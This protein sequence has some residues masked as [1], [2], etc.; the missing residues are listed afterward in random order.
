M[1]PDCFNTLE[2]D[3]ENPTHLILAATGYET[4]NIPQANQQDLMECTS[5]VVI[6]NG[7]TFGEKVGNDGE[8]KVLF[9]PTSHAAPIGLYWPAGIKHKKFMDTVNDLPS[10][11]KPFMVLMEVNKSTIKKW[12]ETVEKQQP[13]FSI[14]IPPAGELYDT[15][16]NKDNTKPRT[17]I[18]ADDYAN[19]MTVMILLWW[20]VYIDK[21]NTDTNNPVLMQTMDKYLVRSSSSHPLE[22]YRGNRV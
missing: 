22:K 2:L 19:Y 6:T 12:I 15:L 9:L 18:D 1:E 17:I 8:Y 20:R 7:K 3:M 5:P 21:I 4:R 13:Q 16:P 10:I 14:D 11:Y